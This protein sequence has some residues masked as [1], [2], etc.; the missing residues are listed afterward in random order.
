MSEDEKDVSRSAAAAAASRARRIGGRIAAPVPR[1]PASD[2]PV[3]EAAEPVIEPAP[4]PSDEPVI[5]LTKPAPK[6]KPAPDR[7]APGRL[8]WT[9]AAVLI[10]AALAMAVLLVTFSHSIWW[11][12][13][14]TSQAQVNRS[15]DQ[16]LAAA[17]SCVVAANSYKYTT[18]DQDEARGVK[19]LTGIQVANYQEAMKALKSDVVK[20]KAAQTPQI[21]EA[22]I[23]SIS[24]DGKRWLIVVYGQLSVTGTGISN[25]QRIDPFAAVVGMQQVGG[26]WLMSCEDVVDRAGQE[27]TAKSTC[28]TS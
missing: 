23:E 25:G 20:V 21:N 4:V 22:G 6:A 15:R 24:S 16:V 19:C 26:K 3:I 10:A 17:K 5:D 18:F 13:P 28:G 14:S 11:A 2:E 7:R 9:P 27:S 1:K 12:K 8:A